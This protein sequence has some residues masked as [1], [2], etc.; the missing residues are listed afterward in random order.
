MNSV[1]PNFADILRVIIAEWNVS[2]IS[3]KHNHVMLTN[4]HFVGDALRK[5]GER[6]QNHY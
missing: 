2:I 3:E 5:D 4:H 6:F 1:E